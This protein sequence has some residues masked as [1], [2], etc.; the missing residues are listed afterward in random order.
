MAG[1]CLYLLKNTLD[2][3]AILLGSFGNRSALGPG[4]KYQTDT[5]DMLVPDRLGGPAYLIVE[6]NSNG[7]VDKFPAVNNNTLVKPIFVNPECPRPTWSPATWPR[8][9]RRSTA[10]RI[11]VTYHVSNLGLAPPMSRAGP[12]PSG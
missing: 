2:G 9:T 7:A 8:R 4:E 11:T 3:S 6:T 10:P 5:N 1:Q 12:T